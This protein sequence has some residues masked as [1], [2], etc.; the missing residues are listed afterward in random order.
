MSVAGSGADH[1]GGKKKPS[2]AAFETSAISPVTDE[3]ETWP[4][5][6]GAILCGLYPPGTIRN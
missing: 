5:R 4:E 1:I 6:T 2:F 3:P